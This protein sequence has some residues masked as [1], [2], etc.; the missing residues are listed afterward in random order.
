MISEL[1]LLYPQHISPPF[2]WKFPAT[3]STPLPVKHHLLVGFIHYALIEIMCKQ[4]FRDLSG[5]PGAKIPFNIWITV[6][7]VSLYLF[8]TFLFGTS[9]VIH[10]KVSQ[11][12]FPCSANMFWWSYVTHGNSPHS[13]ILTLACPC[14]KP[15]CP[16]GHIPLPVFLKH[17]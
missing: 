16:K 4:G 17:P 11:S 1:V 6:G 5:F 13:A 12:T 7:G 10:A 9:H 14:S 8:S 3:F 2:P 15:F